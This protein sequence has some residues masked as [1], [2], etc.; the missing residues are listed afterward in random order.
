[1]QLRDW[2]FGLFGRAARSE[3][4][5]HR[6]RG[7]AM[8]V[9]ILDGTMSSLDP[10]SETNAGQT[11]RLLQEAGRRANLTVY[12]EA[13]IQWRDWSGTWGVITG[14]GINRQIERAYGVLASRYRKGD[15]IILVGYSRG[16]YAV[17][18]LAGVLDYVGLVKAEHATVRTI[19]Q[20]YRHYKTGAKSAAAKR[21]RELYC[22]DKVVI[23]AVAVWDTVK[24][25]GLRLPVVWRWAQSQHGY[26][27]HRLGDHV[28]H[29]F[30]ALALDETREAY[31]P[32]MWEC[33]PGWQ[34]HIEQVWFRGCHGDVGGQVGI[35]PAARPLANIPLVWMLENLETC[36]LT[37]PAGWQA[38]FP[39]DVSAPSVGSWR[40]WGKL[41]LSRRRRIILGTPTESVHPTVLPDEASTLPPRADR[42]GVSPSTNS[43]APR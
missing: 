35:L 2:V 6:K 8:H 12:Y 11:F 32:V 3:E 15:K 24:A 42:Q 5:S 28:R 16:A 20:A 30:H 4:G 17:R 34:G 18:S 26:H 1:M 7:P 9:V 31:A 23:E 22:H 41:F 19:T 21:F 40:A 14:K 10:G 25:L 43:V 27:N 36:G 29:G 38:R 33:P 13:G 37:L 39:Q